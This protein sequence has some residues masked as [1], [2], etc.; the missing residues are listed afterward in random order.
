MAVS[1]SPRRIAA[2]LSF[3]VALTACG[4][5]DGASGSAITPPVVEQVG[6][7]LVTTTVTA[8][9]VGATASATAE[10]RSSNGNVL[11]GRA[12][13]WTSSDAAVASISQTGAITGVGA[14]AVTVT[15]T[16]E[17]RTGSATLNVVPAPVNAVTVSTTS[18]TVV[19]E[20]TLQASVVLRDE[21]NVTLT[22]RD[23]M[24]SSSNTAVAV[25]SNGGVITGVTAGV[26]TIA[27]TAEGKVGSVELTVVPPPVRTV[28]VALGQA[29]LSLGS[30]TSASVTLRDDRNAVLQG[31][32]VAWSSS[33]ASV[34]SVSAAGVVSAVATGTA[35][36]TAE[37]EG[38]SGS[39][40]LTVIL[41]PVAAVVLT[42]PQATLVPGATTQ[43][44]AQAVDLS[45]APLAGRAISWSTNNPAVITVNGSGLVTAVAVG[46]AVISASS[47]GRTGQVSV[48][49]RSPVTNVVFSGSTRVKVGDTYSYT[50]TARTADG[51]VIARPV[52][53]SVR[54]TARALV[55]QGGYVTPLQAGSFTLVARIDGDDWVATYTAYDW[56]TFSSGG[57]GFLTIDADL[58][59]ANRFGRSEYVSLTI[60][61][62]GTGSYYLWLSFPHMVTANGLVAYSFDGATPLT[63]TWDELSP[64]YSTLWKPGSNATVRAFSQRVADAR[65]FTIAW[66]EFNSSS[67]VTSFRVSGLN[68][69]L[70]AHI[71][72]YCPTVA[73]TRSGVDT[74]VDTDDASPAALRRTVEQAL[75]ARAGRVAFANGPAEANA[76]AQRGPSSMSPMLNSWPSWASPAV[77]E[78]RRVPR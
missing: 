59:V 40:T 43:A 45:G 38:A 18:T 78:A 35:T 17:G 1:S 58:Q 49:V 39:A 41:P 55:T 23:V 34:A 6:T 63:E 13:S 48:V 65:V 67:R 60:V 62:G 9:Q 42:I 8:L 30:T 10:L 11:A 26:A 46:S 61:C 28:A 51:A 76:R 21:R 74:G 53:W 52:S 7:V 68:Q 25:V 22:G 47:E 33:N 71:A 24:W 75:A 77:K 14:G 3:V 73:G 72:T 69:R 66:G 19:T 44:V 36:I 56:D 57:R 5:G 4:G 12:V 20:R 70:P 32:T 37:S 29:T 64:S 16:S 50:V 27:A 15:A 31:R 2:A 54:E